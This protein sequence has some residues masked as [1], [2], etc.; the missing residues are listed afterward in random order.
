MR[1]IICRFRNNKDLQVFANK[2]GKNL[3][4][5]VKEVNMV[6]GEIKYKK[7]SIKKGMRKTDWM[8]EWVDMPEWNLDF[9]D[10]TYAKIDF[11][12][13]DDIT[14]SDLT[15]FF[16]GKMTDKSKNCWYPKL[17]M[18]T[19]ADPVIS[20]VAL[21]LYVIGFL[22]VLDLFNPTRKSV[23]CLCMA[24]FISSTLISTTLSYRYTSLGYGLSFLLAVLSIYAIIKIRNHYFGICISGILLGLS[25]ACYQA[26][27]AT[28]CIIAVFYAIYC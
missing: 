5:T 9:K 17:V 23:Q 1:K 2:I 10:E 11:L 18:G 25:M 7:P 20:I 21:A 3:D 19:H 24:L 27:L 4:N 14:A 8:T 13:K 28:F 6:T 26:Y 15:E 22:F 16:D 12:F